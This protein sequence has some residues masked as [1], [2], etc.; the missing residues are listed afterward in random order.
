MKKLYLA[1][2]SNLNVCQ[3]KRR[4]PGAKVYGTALLKD[5]RLAFKGS[6]SGSYLTIEPCPGG[7]VPVAVWEVTKNDIASL[8]CYEGFPNFYYKKDITLSVSR[9]NGE[10]KDTAAFVYIMHENRPYG[11]PSRRYVDICLEGYRNFEFDEDILAE[12]VERSGLK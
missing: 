11:M 3:I 4:C 6:K 10:C 7:F 5:W 1:Y 2:G 12:A 9:N 8:D